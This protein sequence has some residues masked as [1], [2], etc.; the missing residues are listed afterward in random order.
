MD[1]IVIISIKMNEIIGRTSNFEIVMVRVSSIMG[2][3]MIL[4]RSIRISV[5]ATQL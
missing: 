3:R 2:I 5:V 4:A 1:H